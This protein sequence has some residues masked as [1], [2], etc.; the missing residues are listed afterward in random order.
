MRKRARVIQIAPMELSRTADYDRV[1]IFSGSG[2]LSKLVQVL[3]QSCILVSQR[4]K[5]RT[6]HIDDFLGSVDG[7]VDDPNDAKTGLQLV[8]EPH[9]MI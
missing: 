2:E 4:Y 9:R 7:W 8:L 5:R 3:A 1:G 6:F